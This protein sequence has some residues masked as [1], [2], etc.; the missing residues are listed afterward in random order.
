MK[1][2]VK[3]VLAITIVALYA[4]IALALMIWNMVSEAGDMVHYFNQMG[5]ANF[6]LGPVGFVLGHYFRGEPIERG[7]ADV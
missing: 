5:K 3:D 6:L 4:V 1:L 7:R 2:V